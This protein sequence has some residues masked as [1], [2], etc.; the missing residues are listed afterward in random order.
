MAIYFGRLPNTKTNDF[1]MQNEL[2]CKFR[3]Y[4]KKSLKLSMCETEKIYR[5]S[6]KRNINLREG[7]FDWLNERFLDGE[8][9]IFALIV[10][11]H[12]LIRARKKKFQAA[13]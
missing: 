7:E 8:R 12:L 4:R 2:I 11:L 9:K 6:F 13:V 1:I 10:F 3:V 5:I